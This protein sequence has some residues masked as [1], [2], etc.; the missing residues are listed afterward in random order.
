MNSKFDQKS[1]KISTCGN[2]IDKSN[3]LSK[4]TLNSVLRHELQIKQLQK[5]KLP[6]TTT[7]NEIVSQKLTTKL[8]FGA[9]QKVFG[10]LTPI[11]V[12]DSLLMPKAK[13][14]IPKKYSRSSD[15]IPIP[16]LNDFLEVVA[17]H[18]FTVEEPEIK[19]ETIKYE[20]DVMSYYRQLIE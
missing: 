14:S 8:N 18:T 13:T 7:E 17:P 3:K 20:F 6:V 12:N 19:V 15:K 2:L 10:N 16:E 1:Q 9:N 4:P 11:N 5:T